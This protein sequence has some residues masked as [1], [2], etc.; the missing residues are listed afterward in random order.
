MRLLKILPNRDFCLTERLPDNAILQYAILSHTWGD[1][2]QEVTFEDMDKGSGRDKAGYEK[3]R[4]CGEQAR[5]DGLEYFWVDTCCI[6]K[7]DMAELSHAIRSMFRWYRNAA[8][9]Y[10]YLSDVSTNKRRRGDRGTRETW[11]HAFR[12]SKW[13]TRGWTLQELLAP[14]SVEFFSQQR[15]RLGDKKSMAQQIHEITGIPK[16]AFQGAP[17]TRFKRKERFSWMNHRQT[18][19][20]EDKAYSLLGVFDVDMHLRYGEGIASAFKRLDEEIDKVEKCIQELR[21]TDPH[22]DKKRIEDTKGGL[23]EDSFVPLGPGE[24][25]V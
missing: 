17:L 7:K 18:K 10:V 20:E 11:E 2:G 24:L 21:P 22:D 13:F 4:F 15:K 19:L 23:L 3:L 8:R 25:R 14:S 1:E 6:N 12:E 5:L 9:C 16:S